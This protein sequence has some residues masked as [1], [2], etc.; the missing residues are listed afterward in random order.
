MTPYQTAKVHMKGPTRPF[1]S[2]NA[3]H[4]I[5]VKDQARVYQFGNNV[6]CGISMR[7]PMY[8]ERNWKGHVL[9]ADVEE[10]QE[11]KVN[12][13]EVQEPQDRELPLTCAD[14]SVKSGRKRS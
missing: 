12:A 4:P 14:G 9:V 10:L 11:N 7:Y 2:K 3:Y 1:E 13:I 6:L 5:C 8:A